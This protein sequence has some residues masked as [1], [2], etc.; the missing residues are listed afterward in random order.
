M[1]T[2]PPKPRRFL[3]KRTGLLGLAWL[4]LVGGALMWGIDRFEN[5]IED[6]VSEA[7]ATSGFSGV[8]VTV[9]GRDVTIEKVDAAQEAQVIALLENVEGVRNVTKPDDSAA[10]GTTTSRPPSSTSTPP[11]P[12]TSTTSTTVPAAPQA[13]LVATL[14]AGRFHLSGVVPDQATAESLLT[15]ANI[16]YAPFVESDLEV[17]PAVDSPAW[18]AAAPAG[19]SLLPMITDGTIHVEGNQIRLSGHA[20]NPEFLELFRSTVAGVFGLTDVITEVEITNLTSPDFNAQRTGG[21]LRLFG[22]IPN[23]EVRQIIVGGAQAA[24]GENA[25]VDELQVKDGLYTAFWVYTMPGVFQ[26]LTPFPDYE[27][28]VAN[29]VTSGA[30]RGGASFD[31]GSS[32]LTPELTQI[33]QVGA[34]ILTRDFSLGIKIEGHTDSVGSNTLN[35]RLSEARAQA[36]V[37]YLVSAGVAPERLQAVGLGESQPAASNATPGGRKTNRRIEFVFGPVA[38]VVAGA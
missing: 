18:L 29:G 15:A 34:A 1:T 21:A 2:T 4:V 30:L 6:R 31:F 9:N 16:A 26:L 32:E 10:P 11:T 37:A 8:E 35:Q 7:L 19:L 3:N 38:E 27:F 13:S 17:S 20:P 36:A 22:T 12:T 14:E 5:D 33:L 28:R 23:E 25:I 24:Y